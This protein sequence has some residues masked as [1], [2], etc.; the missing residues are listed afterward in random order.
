MDCVIAL[1]NSNSKAT[2]LFQRIHHDNS[3]IK[4]KSMK[5][6]YFICKPREFKIL[7]V[8]IITKFWK[9]GVTFKIQQ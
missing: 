8:Q 6:V 7:Y 5:C 4:R 9:T 1:H 3:S 2:E